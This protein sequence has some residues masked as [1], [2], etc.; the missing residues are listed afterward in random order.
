MKNNS[1]AKIFAIFCSKMISKS[2]KSEI[3]S[4]FRS[5][6]LTIWRGFLISKC[7]DL[8]P[9]IDCHAKINFDL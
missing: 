5:S 7:D 8:T 2:K 3:R 4:N 1:I 9:R 6:L